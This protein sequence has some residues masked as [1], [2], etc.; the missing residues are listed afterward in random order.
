MVCKPSRGGGG[1]GVVL[2]F[3]GSRE[4]LERAR[5]FDP[6]DDYLVQEVV[7]PVRIDGRPAWFRV[8][9]CLGRSFPLFWWSPREDASQSLRAEHIDEARMSPVD[10]EAVG[11][12]EYRELERVT[13][14]IA[15][16]SGARWFSCEI[17]LVERPHGLTFVPIDYVNDA[18]YARTQ[19][20][21]GPKGVPESTAEAIAMHLVDAVAGLP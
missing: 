13:S 16:V 14:T 2:P 11:H 10:P 18:C 1:R 21:V 17:A 6:Q 9:F 15:R 7:E 4:A 19:R 20:E 3:D 12:E 5:C 8:Y